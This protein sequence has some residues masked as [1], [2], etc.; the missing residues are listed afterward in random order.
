VYGFIICEYEE[1]KK[2]FP[3]FKAVLEEVKNRLIAKAE[4]DWAPLKY[5]GL[6]PKAGEF[7]ESTIMPQLFKDISGN[8]LTT[9]N[10]W[11]NATGAQ[12]ILTGAA[13]GNTI[14]EDYKVGFVGFAILDPVIRFSEFKMQIGD[15]KF[16]RVNIEE[17]FAYEEP[18]IIFER[19]FIL[20]E[21][22]S[23]ELVAYVLTQGPQR[24]K[25]IGTQV[26]R[27]PN[28]LQITDTGAALT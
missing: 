11:F 24:L 15:R 7:G 6:T 14:Y 20:D 10:Q 8:V 28:K 21:E 4:A 18:C 2:Q 5:G 16:P 19:G 27:V 22:T 25:L 17:A 12:T 26:N 1:V 13:S 9:W 3:E 23:F